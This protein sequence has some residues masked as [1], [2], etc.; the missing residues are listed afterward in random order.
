[1]VFDEGLLS[2]HWG[3]WVDLHMEVTFG[4]CEQFGI[5]GLARQLKC[6]DPQVVAN[7]TNSYWQI[8]GNRGY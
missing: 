6:E 2:D 1:M 3:M 7:I 8:S 5:M 4:S